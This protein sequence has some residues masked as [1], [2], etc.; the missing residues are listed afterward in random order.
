[1]S[2]KIVAVSADDVT[3]YTLPGNSGEFTRDGAVVDDTIFGQTFRSGITGII[4]WGVN[5]NAVYKGYPGFKT[6]LKKQGTSTT[7]TDEASTLVSGK[8]YQINATTKRIWDRTASFVIKDGGVDH[9]SDVES[10]DF[11]FG[12]VTFKSAYSVTGAVTISGKYYTTSAIGKAQSYTLTQTAE[13]IDTT[14][15]ATAQSNSGLRTH[16]PGLRTVSIEVPSVFNASDDWHTQLLNRNELIIEI[17]PDGLG[18]SA[19]S[20]ARGFFRL[21]SDRQQGNVGALEQETLNFT[22]NV[23]LATS[24]PSIELPFNWLHAGSSPIPTAVKKILNAFIN[25]DLLYVQYLPDGATGWKGQ[26]VVTNFT[27]S[28]GMDSMNTFAFNLMG[29]GGLTAV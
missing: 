21:G 11:L 14:D 9:T 28:G 13:A 29:T 26:G 20:L 6:T 5:S 7:M 16:T 4:G 12:T 15:F 10:I 1:M 19:G 18:A 17:N 24:G 22:L 8:T 3:Y 25:E 2:A 27:L 23:P